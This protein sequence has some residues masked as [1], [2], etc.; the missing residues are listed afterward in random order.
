MEVPAR[1]RT[2]PRRGPQMISDDL[3]WSHVTSDDLEMNLHEDLQK[4]KP[5]IITDGNENPTF[6]TVVKFVIIT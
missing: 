1:T 2:D 4:N 5:H 6:T 3:R